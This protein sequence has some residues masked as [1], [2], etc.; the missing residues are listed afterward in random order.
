M[1]IEHKILAN[2]VHLLIFEKQKDITSTFLRFQEY[3][4]SPK[5]K[6][7]V[8]S[9]KDF[10]E[11]YKKNSP[12]GIKTGKFTY[13]S[14]WNGFNIPSYVLKPFYKGLFNPISVKEKKILDI[15]DKEKGIF[16]IIGVHKES[17]ISDNVLKHE[18]AHGLFYTNKKYKEEIISL[19]SKFNLDKIK[20]ELRSRAG[21]HE[22]VLDDEVHAYG[23]IYGGKLKI[24]FPKKLQVGLEKIY[25]KY[26][27]NN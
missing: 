24:S 1:K 27:H 23:I 26:T 5:F 3:Y 12:N 21:Y 7:K 2:K 13:Y 6:G 17:K 11:W 10:K 4:E 14:D 9:L 18:I 19:L 22:A 16:Y 25:K 15:F 20:E 8:F